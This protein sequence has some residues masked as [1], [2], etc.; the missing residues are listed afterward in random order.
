MIRDFSFLSPTTSMYSLL[1]S[2]GLVLMEKSHEVSL[3]LLHA[4]FNYTE[5]A[6]PC[7]LLILP[8]VPCLPISAKFCT[9]LNV[10]GNVSWYNFFW[11][12]PYSV[13][14]GWYCWSFFPTAY[15]DMLMGKN[16]N[17]RIR[18]N[19]TNKCFPSWN[20][21]VVMRWVLNCYLV[22]KRST[23]TMMIIAWIALGVSWPAGFGVVAL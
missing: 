15:C 3:L 13:F 10:L 5:T 9:E 2:F 11:S 14:Q 7:Y 18:Q 20:P 6:V 19:Q 16:R 12:A 21:V 4:M 1:L 22:A 8:S 17:S 23:V